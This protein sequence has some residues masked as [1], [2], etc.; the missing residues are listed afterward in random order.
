MSTHLDVCGVVSIRPGEK[1][2][3]FVGII[4]GAI[5]GKDQEDLFPLGDVIVL[6]EDNAEVAYVDFGMVN[7][8]L[9]TYEAVEK[10]MLAMAPFVDVSPDGWVEVDLVP[11]FNARNASMYRF[12]GGG[13]ECSSA[14]LRS[15]GDWYAVES[16]LKRMKIPADQPPGVPELTEDDW[17]EIYSAVESKALS[18]E[19]GQYGPDLRGASWPEHLRSILEKIGPDGENMRRGCK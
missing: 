13:V 19:Q 10:A 11:G 4:V 5:G 3:V 8:D 2:E 1:A 15:D 7:A 17:T 6:C 14:N 16:N 12:I 18:V 9:A